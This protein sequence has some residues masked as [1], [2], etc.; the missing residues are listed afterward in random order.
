MKNEYNA[1][2]KAVY[3]AE[4]QQQIIDLKGDLDVSIQILADQINAGKSEH[5]LD[6]L[7]FCATLHTYSARNTKL[8]EIQCRRRGLGGVN[9][10]ASFRSWLKHGYAP[11]KGEKG[12]AILV[13]IP[14]KKERKKHFEDK[15][16]LEEEQGIV[17][18]IGYVFMDCQIYPLREDVPSIPT[19]FLPQVGDCDE[20]NRRLLAAIR[21]DGIRVREGNVY[22]E[23]AYSAHGEIGLLP[24]LNGASMF[25]H[26]I[27]EYA[28]ELLHW[29]AFDLPKQTEECHAESI[30][31]LCCQHYGVENLQ[32]SDYLLSWRVDE[33]FLM[34][35]LEIIRK[36]AA[37]VIQKIEGTTTAIS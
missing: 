34:S 10:A 3:K 2:E 18:R 35:Q 19:F 7:K 25:H 31:F 17:F 12:V 30:A 20:L 16:V 28:H 36:T 8:I 1:E 26:L 22:R 21:S 37:T 27:H 15:D 32:S 29:G 6:Y 23:Q 14:Y 33:K 5:F 11:K 9:H 4:K 13:P 24:G